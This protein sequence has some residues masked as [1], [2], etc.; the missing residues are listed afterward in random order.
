MYVSL[1][2]YMQHNTPFYMFNKDNMKHVTW[3]KQGHMECM[4][5]LFGKDDIT[6]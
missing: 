1:P 2:N 4:G 6:F 3:V 5:F